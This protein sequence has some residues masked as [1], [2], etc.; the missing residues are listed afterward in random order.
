MLFSLPLLADVQPTEFSRA[1]RAIHLSVLLCFLS[2]FPSIAEGNS[3][4]FKPYNMPERSLW[5]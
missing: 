5:R 3:H 2:E 4:A 1:T